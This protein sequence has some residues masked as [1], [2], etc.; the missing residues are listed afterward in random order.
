MH[1]SFGRRKFQ[2]L[3]ERDVLADQACT[4]AGVGSNIGGDHSVCFPDI[5]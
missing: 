2:P 3:F 5:S 4:L 1:P